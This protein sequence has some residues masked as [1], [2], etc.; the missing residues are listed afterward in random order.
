MNYSDIVKEVKEEISEDKKTYVYTKTDIDNLFP[1]KEKPNKKELSYQRY[2]VNAHLVEIVQN[3]MIKYEYFIDDK[4]DDVYD[5]IF[6]LVEK[7]SVISKVEEEEEDDEDQEWE[8]C[9]EQF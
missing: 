1:P 6:K 2:A 4:R 8:S 7:H 9:L 3:M 5:C